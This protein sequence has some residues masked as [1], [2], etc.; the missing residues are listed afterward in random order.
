MDL[1]YSVLSG[2]YLDGTKHSKTHVYSTGSGTRNDPV[3]V[4]SAEVTIQEFWIRTPD[5]SE[6]KITLQNVDVDA[7]HG[8]D[9]AMVIA[10]NDDQAA[11]IGYV[12]F[13]TKQSFFF[14]RTSVARGFAQG[15]APCVLTIVLAFIAGGVAGYIEGF[16]ACIVAFAVGLV[17]SVVVRNI[18]AV[19]IE[20]D[21][22]K[23]FN[24]IIMEEAHLY[25]PSER[26]QIMDSATP[27]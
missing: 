16:M 23:K 9:I 20:A 22:R 8:H 13:T 19:S 4:Q 5:G 6:E 25:V 27:S 14:Q 3:R 7:R 1:N 17:A 10:E 24:E 21:L 12:N 2:V 15:A 26:T 18:H 11:Y